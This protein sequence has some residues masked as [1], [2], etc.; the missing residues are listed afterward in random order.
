VLDLMRSYSLAANVSARTMLLDM[1]LRK[2]NSAKSGLGKPIT[3][4]E[5][6]TS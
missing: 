2:S 3:D 5:D 4:Y 1:F 6:S